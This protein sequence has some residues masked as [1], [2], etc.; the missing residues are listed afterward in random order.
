MGRWAPYATC[1]TCGTGFFP[2]A[3]GETFWGQGHEPDAEQ[4]AEWGGRD[5]QR[6]ALLGPGRGRVLDVG[7]GFGHFVRWAGEHGWDAWGVD[8]DPWARERTVAPGR[9]HAD[10]AE[11]GEP[12]DVVT[13]WD[14]L[15]HVADP[16]AFAASVR[17][18]LRPGGRVLAGSPNF[19]ALKLRWPFLRR[20]P[21]RFR[22]LVRP[23][24]HVVQFTEAGL[25][26]AL[27]RAGYGRP[28]PLR[29]PLARRSRTAENW[30]ARRFPQL[31]RGLFVEAFAD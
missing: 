11:F 24:E 14:V 28:R 7:C 26:L 23:E 3:L 20:D 9:V 6:A 31:R 21:D 22:E 13:L 25:S 5:A 19:D 30:M 8:F 17:G 10:V 4:E 2:H 15:E 16:I 18:C 12:F 27:E 29:P 1:P